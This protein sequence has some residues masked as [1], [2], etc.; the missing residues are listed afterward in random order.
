MPSAPY[1]ISGVVYESYETDSSQDTGVNAVSVRVY[2]VTNSEYSSWV[3][4]NSS[5]QYT[6]DLANMTTAYLD[7]DVIFIETLF[8]SGVNASSSCERIVV[9]TG[10]GS[11]TQNLYLHSGIMTENTT[12]LYTVILHNKSTAAG[13]IKFYSRING[14]LVLQMNVGSNTLGV[15]PLFNS[16]EGIHCNGGFF[17]INSEKTIDSN[18][19]WR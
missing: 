8:V 14:R 2:N 16:N 6:I 17:K 9:D 11:D 15:S 1:P 18:E 4:T 7:N 10:V 19:V 12:K 13:S 5:G 3:T